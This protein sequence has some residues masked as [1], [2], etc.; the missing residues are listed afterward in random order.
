M[1]CI[2]ALWLLKG[3]NQL[4]NIPVT[5]YTD[6]QSFIQSIGSRRAKSGSYLTDEFVKVAEQLTRGLPPSPPKLRIKISWIAAR[7]G[8]AGNEKADRKARSAA[9]GLTSTH[10]QLPPILR[11]PLPLNADLIKE[12]FSLTLREE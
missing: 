7:S 2:L 10:N 8:V 5:I 11:K 3:E 6:S 1:G 9:N 4:S 12:Q